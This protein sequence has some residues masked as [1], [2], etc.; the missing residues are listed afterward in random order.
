M[1]R[2]LWLMAILLVLTVSGQTWADGV[3]PDEPIEYVP[4]PLGNK[5]FP[6]ITPVISYEQNTDSFAFSY[7][8]FF[9]PQSSQNLF[10]IKFL[11]EIEKDE[12]LSGETTG[13]CS[14][15]HFR[16]DLIHES[17][18]PGISVITDD[19][20]SYGP[21]TTLEDTVIRSSGLPGIIDTLT[22]GDVPPPS[23]QQVI[24]PPTEP[25]TY[26]SR[27]TKVV[28]VGPVKRPDNLTPQTHA[29]YLY[30][31]A[32]KALELNWIEA[33]DNILSGLN[34]VR[35]SSGEIQIEAA[36]EVLESLE[37]KRG[38]T[39]TEEGYYLIKPNLDKLL[40]DLGWVPTSE[41]TWFAAKDTILSLRNDSTNDGANPLLTLEKIKGKA[42]RSAIGFDLSEVDTNRLSKATLKLTID[43]NSHVT[44]WGNGKTI[45]LR[46]VTTDWVE[47]N[48]VNFGLKKKS[49]VPGDGTGA[50]WLA[51]EANAYDWDG[52]WSRSI[53]STSAP[54]VI[55]N[56]LQGTVEFD[57]TGDIL[58]SS[59]SGWLILKEDENQ[60][61]KVSFYSREGASQAG[62]LELGPHLLLEYGG[63]FS[64]R[65]S[66]GSLIA[67]LTEPLRLTLS[68]LLAVFS[69]TQISARV[70][71]PG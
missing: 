70:G 2:A 61:S 47:G 35:S 49:Q 46:A 67:K 8:I 25:V 31:E 58:N 32:E 51:P 4:F 63:Q 3:N 29:D 12:Y 28:T 38:G 65:S 71:T 68:S 64:K 55:T 48:G 5:I 62:A 39:V 24:L 50:T 27:R 16:R 37:Q 42:T 14:V 59:V 9:L 40:H 11:T 44:G 56:H 6:A 30:T 7:D 20:L 54:I 53:S 60:G 57:V 45:K 34:T 1:K 41:E 18:P 69:D 21:G 10:S 19:D 52:A 17:V 23:D 36:L 33:S 26:Y 22:E 66:S 15:H 13:G 43:P